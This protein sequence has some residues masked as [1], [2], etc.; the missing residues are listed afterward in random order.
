MSIAE[1]ILLFL[2]KRLLR[3]EF[4]GLED[5]LFKIGR[6]KDKGTLILSNHPSYIDPIILFLEIRKKANVIPVIGENLYVSYKKFLKR[7]SP[8]IV[9]NFETGTSNVKIKHLNIAIEKTKK[10]LKESKQLL[11][12]PSGKVQAKK[13]ESIGNA[14]FVHEVLKGLQKKDVNIFLVNVKG[15]W[16]SAFSLKNEYSKSFIRKTLLY[17]KSSVGLCENKISKEI[18]FDIVDFSSKRL[19][20]SSLSSLNKKLDSFFQE[21]TLCNACKSNSVKTTKRNKEFLKA[22]K[23]S[24][25]SIGYNVKKIEFNTNL[26]SDIGLDSIDRAKVIAGAGDRLKQRFFSLHP[27]IKAIKIDYDNA[28]LQ[29]KKETKVFQESIKNIAKEGVKVSKIEYLDSDSLLDAFI[30]VQKEVKGD[31]LICDNKGKYSADKILMYS[32]ALANI[33]RKKYNKNKYIGVL[34]P[35]C[36]HGVIC[37]LAA[38]IAK[39]IPVMLG[40]K[41]KQYESEI[42]KLGINYVLTSYEFIDKAV[43]DISIDLYDKLIFLETIMKDDVDVDAMKNMLFGDIPKL[44]KDDC[45][46][47]LMTSGVS[48]K[49]KAVPLTHR[50]ILEN[51]RTY[52]DLFLEGSQHMSGPVFNCLPLFHSYGLFTGTMAPILSA[53]PVVL[54]NNPIASNVVDIIS[55]SRPSVVFTIPSIV[56][57]WKYFVRKKRSILVKKVKIITGAEAITKSVHQDLKKM[58]TNMDLWVGYGLTECSPVISCGRFNGEKSVGKALSN[59]R[60]IVKKTGKLNEGEIMVSGPSVFSGYLHNKKRDDF[61]TIGKEVFFNTKDIGC[62]NQSGDLI[63]SGRRDRIIKK[64]GEKVS[65]DAVANKASERFKQDRMAILIISSVVYLVVERRLRMTEVNKFLSSFTELR[66]DRLVVIQEIPL[67]SSGKIDLKSIEKHL[68]KK[69]NS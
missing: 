4:N 3:C 1:S 52:S 54:V 26:D 37:I 39:K 63:L 23:D 66:I 69:V 6:Q 18:I 17:V 46:I 16:D 33:I 53:V 13:C 7:Y 64:Y 42:N 61:V 9:P 57:G 31:L 36:A 49:S 11:I 48:G 68:N 14:F 32:Q 60:V 29:S 50:N 27:E 47:V 24:I 58:F 40:H 15:A 5:M 45:A 2:I 56:K 21:E 55:A 22:M 67:L 25:A 20:G 43:R 8:I 44:H 19:Y 62:I 10:A 65:L 35:L 38:M 34:M 28:K 41:T 51:I 59:L 30:R 12:Y